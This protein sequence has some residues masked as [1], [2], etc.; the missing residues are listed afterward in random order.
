MNC[1]GCHH[2]KELHGPA[3]LSVP[4]LIAI[5]KDMHREYVS[6]PADYEYGCLLCLCPAYMPRQVS[7]SVDLDR[8]DRGLNWLSSVVDW[9]SPDGAAGRELWEDLR[10]IQ[11]A[12]SAS[13]EPAQPEPAA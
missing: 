6:I 8:L 11:Y 3:T 1:A 9:V 10:V 7:V 5:A 13:E 12:A 4:E 2:R